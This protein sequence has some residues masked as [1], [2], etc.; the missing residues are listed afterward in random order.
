MELLQLT[1]FCDAAETENFS[2][3]A[4]TYRVPTSN[5]SQ[6]IHRLETELGVL[7]F[8]RLANRVSLNDNGRFFYTNIKS[9]LTMIGD[10]KNKLCDID[11]IS[12]EIKILVE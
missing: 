9:A 4:K 12:G 8:D 10:A 11:E 3:T 2:Q 6:S 1:Y 5:I 7:L